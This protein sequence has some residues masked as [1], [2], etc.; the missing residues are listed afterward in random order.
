MKG[1]QH[2]QRLSVL[3]TRRGLAVRVQSS[4]AAVLR[5][6]VWSKQEDVHLQPL[7]I[8][9]SVVLPAAAKDGGGPTHQVDDKILQNNGHLC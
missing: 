1:L 9:P 4:D 3:S 5:Q 2:R 7:L 8:L 6:H